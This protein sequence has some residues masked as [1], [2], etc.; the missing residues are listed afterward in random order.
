MCCWVTRPRDLLN[1]RIYSTEMTRGLKIVHY[2]LGIS[3]E[4]FY[5]LTSTIES[6]IKT[7][8]ILSKHFKQSYLIWIHL[9]H[10]VNLFCSSF[11]SFSGQHRSTTLEKLW[12]GKEKWKT[13]SLI[14]DRIELTPDTVRFTS[15]Y[16]VSISIR[17]NA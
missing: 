4:H 14:I 13:P 15:E 2:Q 12:T 17:L 8:I 9:L 6:S 1:W 7:W 5:R 3:R 16:S 10:S 11:Q